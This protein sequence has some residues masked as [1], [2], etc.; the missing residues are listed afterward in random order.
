MKEEYIGIKMEISI[1]LTVILTVV[2]TLGVGLGI[3]FIKL[4]PPRIEASKRRG[5]LL[6]EIK[7][8]AAKMEEDIFKVEY[9]YGRQPNNSIEDVLLSKRA[10]QY[11]KKLLEASRD[12]SDM[13]SIT[14][15]MVENVISKQFGKKLKSIE[16]YKKRAIYEFT[17]YNETTDIGDAICKWLLRN[18]ANHEIIKCILEGKDLDSECF[19]K[20]DVMRSTSIEE[21]DKFKRLIES[22]DISFKGLLSDLGDKLK[23]DPSMRFLKAYR[24]K[25]MKTAKHFEKYLE[26]DRKKSQSWIGFRY[27]IVNEETLEK[28]KNYVEPKEISEEIS[29]R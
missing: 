14:L 9:T 10:K 23:S 13:L 21:R 5:K 7:E 22:A 16:G 18:N 19:F 15:P 12:Y 26:S 2:S 3:L 20:K 17:G 6:K 4:I 29:F 11:L 8:K 28:V 1:A 24:E 25:A 27:K